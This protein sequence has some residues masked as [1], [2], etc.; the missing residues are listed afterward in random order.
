MFTSCPFIRRRRTVKGP[1]LFGGPTR[2]ANPGPRTGSALARGV[3][4]RL[5]GHLDVVRVALLEPGRRDPDEPTALLQVGDRTRPDV[6][7]RLT[8]TTDQLVGHRRQRAAEGHL[9]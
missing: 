5:D 2:S 8:Q 4:G 3:V 6:E 7:H 9:T 1:S